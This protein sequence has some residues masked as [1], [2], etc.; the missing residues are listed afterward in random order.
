M[1]LF[2]ILVISVG[3]IIVLGIFLYYI[4]REDFDEPTRL[5]CS[6]CL[7]LLFWIG[8]GCL[9]RSK[10]R[11][12]EWRTIHACQKWQ[13]PRD[14]KRYAACG[15]LEPIARPLKAPLSGRS[16]VMYDY[17]MTRLVKRNI[18]S[19][20]GSQTTGEI[21]FSGAALTPSIIRTR[22]G[23]VKLLGY[24]A[25]DGFPTEVV[26]D[27]T[28]ANRYIK[29][30]TFKEQRG[31]IKL[32]TFQ[33]MEDIVTDDD[34]H[35]RSDWRFFDNE[36]AFGLVLHEIIVPP[37]TQVC[38]IGMYKAQVGGLVNDRIGS[39]YSL[40]L[41]KGDAKATMRS[42]SNQAIVSLI[43]GLVLFFSSAISIS[44]LIMKWMDKI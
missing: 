28:I 24:S 40:R 9:V 44:H 33:A 23:P 15:V 10:I 43:F 2:R 4:M 31:T 8:Y 16:C 39:G 32:S 17:E 6:I 19:T 14:G 12:M 36:N 37:G 5:V 26:E 42:L 1:K 21:V 3:R 18:H 30:T 27:C 25:L 20:I 7:P 34:G 29:S 11:F 22:F 35:I 13:K 41:I 38:A